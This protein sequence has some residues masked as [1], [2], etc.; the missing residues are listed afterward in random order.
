MTKFTIVIT[1]IIG[2]IT[3][4]KILDKYGNVSIKQTR[5]YVMDKSYILTKVIL[6]WLEHFAL[7]LGGAVGGW[8]LFKRKVKKTRNT[9]NQYM[10]REEVRSIVKAENNYWKVAEVKEITKEKPKELI[11]PEYAKPLINALGDYFL[12]SNFRTKVEI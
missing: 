1:T 9:P 4:D 5:R 2:L 12:W 7:I 3:L 8:L 6:L 11:C 10:T